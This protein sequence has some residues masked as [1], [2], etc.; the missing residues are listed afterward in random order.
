M[1]KNYIVKEKISIIR[2][3]AL[4]IRRKLNIK[5][6]KIFFLIILPPPAHSLRHLSFHTPGINNHRP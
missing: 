6:E 5:Q 3:D 2:G 1:F 4:Y